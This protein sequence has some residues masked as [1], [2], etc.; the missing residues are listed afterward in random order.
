MRLDFDADQ[1]AVRE[2]IAAALKGASGDRIREI[3]GRGF[4]DTEY[5][6]LG[7][8]GMFG[9]AAGEPV[10]SPGGGQVEACLLA[11]QLGLHAA[12]SPVLACVVQAAGALRPHPRFA[13]QYGRLVAAEAVWTWAHLEAA[14]RPDRPPALRAVPDG[15]GLVLTGEKA[16]VEWGTRAERFVVTAT[17]DGEPLVVVAAADAAGV[18]AAP[19]QTSTGGEIARVAFDRTPVAA[20]DV[21]ARGDA[22]VRLI[23]A[24]WRRTLLFQSAYLVGLGRR[25]L[26]LTIAHATVREQ[27]GRPLGAFQAVKHALA[28]SHIALLAARLL[29][30]ETA[31]G[32]ALRTPVA[33][34]AAMKAWVAEATTQALRVA[35]EIHGGLG[36]VDDHEVTL[37]FRRALAE[38]QLHGS[39][40]QLWELAAQARADIGAGTRRPPH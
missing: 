14:T 35:H 26:D 15:G 12:V 7:Q 17:A 2:A 8:M 20:A 40:S 31:S 6:A 16:F 9:F 24:T 10:D 21:L 5:R 38:S 33:A 22:A 27:F 37:L 32:T 36:A 23:A 1:L 11:E 3:W 4:L 25:A 19:R 13:E 34:L 18:T 29:V 39:A 30:F 28:D